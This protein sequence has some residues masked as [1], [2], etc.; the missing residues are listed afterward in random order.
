MAIR[1]DL[2]N[3]SS[4]RQ[5]V[6]DVVAH[7]GRIDGFISTVGTQLELQPFTDISDDTIDSMIDVELTSVIVKVQAV[8]REIVRTGSGRIVLVGSDSGKVGTIGECVSAACRAGIIALAKSVAREYAR[9]K[10]L[11]NVVSP[12][13]QTRNSGTPSSPA[14]TSPHES[15]AP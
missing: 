3:R 11:A 2:S 9:H 4:A 10:I 12:A 6:T 1:A 7:F 15:A 5:M 13:P 8:A 14:T